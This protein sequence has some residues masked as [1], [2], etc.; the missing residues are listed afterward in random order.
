MCIKYYASKPKDALTVQKDGG[1]VFFDSFFAEYYDLEF[2]VTV[3]NETFN[4]YISIHKR[5]KPGCDD[6]PDTVC[7]TPCCA[8]H[9]HCYHINKCTFKSWMNPYAS[10][11]CKACNDAVVSC[12]NSNMFCCSS[13]FKGYAPCGCETHRCYSRETGFYCGKPT[14][15]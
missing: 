13:T 3:A 8:D 15:L 12:M 11:E 1:L 14:C 4:G 10:K 5:D 7:T 9:D 2:T 6:F